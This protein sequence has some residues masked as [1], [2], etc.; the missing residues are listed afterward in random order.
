MPKSPV[1][2]PIRLNLPKLESPSITRQM[3]EYEH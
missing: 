1:R 3:V 2:S